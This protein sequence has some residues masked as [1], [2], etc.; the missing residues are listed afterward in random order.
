MM[1]H[2]DRTGPIAILSSIGIVTVFGW[3]YYLA[4]TFSIQVG[5]Y[6]LFSFSFNN[7]L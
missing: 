6:D 4:L 5:I 7:A 3:A 1:Y 2:S